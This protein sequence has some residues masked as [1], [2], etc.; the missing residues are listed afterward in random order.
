M[1][2]PTRFLKLVLGHA[3]GGAGSWGHLQV[4]SRASARARERTRARPQKRT[5][6]PQHDLM[7]EG[8]V[9]ATREVTVALDGKAHG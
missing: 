1:I 2:D 3:S 5:A 6:C 4:R 8:N 7:A 9:H